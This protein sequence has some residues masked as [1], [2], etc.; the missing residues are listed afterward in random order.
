MSS[1]VEQESRMTEQKAPQT[2]LDKAFGVPAQRGGVVEENLNFC[3]CQLIQR[4]SMPPVS[5]QYAIRNL[6]LGAFAVL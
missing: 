1:P 4:D 3:H 2:D 6:L 5:L